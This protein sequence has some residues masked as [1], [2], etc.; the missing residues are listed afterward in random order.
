M[1]AVP[2]GLLTTLELTAV[3]TVAS[4]SVQ[5]PSS[6]AA[7]SLWAD[8]AL[9]LGI[10]TGGWRPAGPRGMLPFSYSHHKGHNKEFRNGA[11]SPYSVYSNVRTL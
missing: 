4:A 11:A 5:L 1:E 2:T 10:H 9:L 7:G 6:L 3:P 8:I